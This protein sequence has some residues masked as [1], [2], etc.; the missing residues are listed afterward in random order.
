MTEIRG[1][2]DIN[3]SYVAMTRA[4]NDLLAANYG[5]FFKILKTKGTREIIPILKYF[6]SANK[7]N[8]TNSKKISYNN[9][10]ERI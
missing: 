5:A 10:I 4:E 1:V 8:L 7:L 9:N 6:V 2:E 3:I